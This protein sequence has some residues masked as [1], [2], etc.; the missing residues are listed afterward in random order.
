MT[1]NGD[2][3]S[4]CDDENALDLMLI[5]AQLCAFLKITELYT[6]RANCLVCELYPIKLLLFLI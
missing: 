5:T 3:I 4:F 6:L 2:Q 1:A